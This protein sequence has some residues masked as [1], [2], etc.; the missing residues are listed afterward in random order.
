MNFIYCCEIRAEKSLL[1]SGPHC[2]GNDEQ[3]QGV[4]H[5]LE[6][7][8]QEADAAHALVIVVHAGEVAERLHG[9]GD[10]QS[11]WSNHNQ[12]IICWLENFL[13]NSAQPR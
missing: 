11:A 5:V 7:G 4:Q 6:R 3:L 12:I 13:P 8:D 10:N 2:Q 9:E 1:E